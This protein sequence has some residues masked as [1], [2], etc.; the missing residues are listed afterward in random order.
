MIVTTKKARGMF[1]GCRSRGS[2]YDPFREQII[3]WCEAGVPVKTMAS[4]LGTDYTWQGVD[5]YIRSRGLRPIG[6]QAVI[7]ARN[8]CDRCEFCKNYINTNNGKGRICTKSWRTIQKGV[9]YCP[10]WCEKETEYEK[11]GITNIRID[12]IGETGGNSELHSAQAD[13]V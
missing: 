6:K 4:I 3:G 10:T 12:G 2:K 9:V 5:Q 11:N 1:F 8:C 13:K 7:G